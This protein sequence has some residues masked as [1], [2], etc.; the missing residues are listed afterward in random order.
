MSD[1][2]KKKIPKLLEDGLDLELKPSDLRS[3]YLTALDILLDMAQTSQD[4]RMKLQA[5]QG[6]HS[7]YMT[8][9]VKDFSDEA[10]TKMATTQRQTLSEVRKLREQND[11]KA[12]DEEDE[13]NGE[14]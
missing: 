9:A 10:T 5:L 14:D 4:P 1:V 13:S 2:P 3:H 8:V 6:I 7:Y 12:W 11:K